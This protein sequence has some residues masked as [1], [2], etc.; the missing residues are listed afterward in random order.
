MK[1]T[2]SG[3]YFPVFSMRS[4]PRSTFRTMPIL[5]SAEWCLR[6]AQR[7]LRT[8]F[9]D[10]HPRGWGGG[11]L[12]YFHSPWGY[13]EPEILRHSNRQFGPIG[14]DAGHTRKFASCSSR[15]NLRIMTL[16][17]STR[18]N[19]PSPSSRASAARSGVRDM[20]DASAIRRSAMMVPSGKLRS[21]IMLRSR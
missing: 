5:S 12:A 4:S 14:A 21:I 19:S 11:F 9:F 1:A 6:V 18:V 8:S 13:D 2:V 3:R 17:V 7:I 15:E 16:P 10:W 20:P